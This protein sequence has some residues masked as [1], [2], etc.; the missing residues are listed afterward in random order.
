MPSPEQL[1]PAQRRLESAVSKV[2]RKLAGFRW[3]FMPLGLVAL[4][5]VGVH[6]AADVVDDRILWLVDLVDGWFD[7]VVGR[8]D[9]TANLVHLLDFEQRVKLARSVALVWELVADV[10]LCWPALG[11]REKDAHKPS[12]LETSIEGTH[13]WKQLFRRVKTRPTTMRIFRPVAV[14]AVA[15]A[16]ACAVGR[17]VEGAVYLTVRDVTGDGPGGLLGRV[18]ALAAMAGALYALGWR[19]VLRTLQDADVMSDDG[20]PSRQEAI[21]RGLVGSCVV[22]PLAVAA[23]F[24]ATPILSFFR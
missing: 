3:A 6:A 1:S 21:W 17:M 2:S 14:A 10:I 24:G 16:G 15:L 20:N 11:Y 19:A 12:L 8:F 5:A 9:L 7:G 13:G 22:F 4:I 18:V 23:L